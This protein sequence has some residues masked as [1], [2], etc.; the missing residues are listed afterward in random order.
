[1]EEKYYTVKQTAERLGLE[2]ATIR[3]YLTR[4]ILTRKKVFNSTVIE[5]EEVEE[6]KR[7]RD[8]WFKSR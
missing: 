7:R 6:Y 2:V 5:I 8:G 4:G 3:K 1:M